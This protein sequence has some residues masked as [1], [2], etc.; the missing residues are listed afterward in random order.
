MN[1]PF[2]LNVQRDVAYIRVH[3][4]DPLRR[5]WRCLP[6]DVVLDFDPDGD[7]VG[8]ELLNARRQLE[9]LGVRV[10]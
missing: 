9:A 8:L 3:T 5:A 7:F 6:V 10:P 2:E 1:I 4:H